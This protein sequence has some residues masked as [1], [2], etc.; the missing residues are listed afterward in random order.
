MVEELERAC[1]EVGKDPA[2]LL[3]SLDIQVDP[4]SRHDE[5]EKPITGT[6]EEIAEGDPGFPGDR[7]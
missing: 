5:G 6:S 4:L 2:T 3:R 7:R 1:Q